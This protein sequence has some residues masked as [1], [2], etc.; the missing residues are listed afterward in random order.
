MLAPPPAARVHTVFCAECTED[1][2]YKSLG[3]FHSHNLSGMPGGV[4]RLLACDKEELKTYRG[5]HIGPTF[6]HQNHKRIWHT[7]ALGPGETDHPFGAARNDS[8]GSY[9]KPGSIM[10][11][12]REAPEAKGVEYVLYIDADML[13]RKPMDPIAMGVRRGVVVSEHVGYL[14]VGLLPHTLTRTP[15]TARGPHTLCPDTHPNHNPD[16]GPN[17]TPG[18]SQER[19]RAPLPTVGGAAGQRGARPRPVPGAAVRGRALQR[20]QPSAQVARRRGLVPLLPH[21]RHPCDRA[22]LVPPPP[23]TLACIP[24]PNPNPNPSPKPKPKPNPDLPQRRLRAL[25]REH[26][27]LRLG[28]GLG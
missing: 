2:D 3:V 27:G 18:G 1:Y 19:P 25:A 7:R 17:P 13:L 20:R 22:A 6:V 14:D 21:G 10:H 23:P 24:I 28:L 8:S 5:L 4:T 9:N 11:W 15:S 16:H 12:V 26:L